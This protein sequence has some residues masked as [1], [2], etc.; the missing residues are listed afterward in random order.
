MKFLIAFAIASLLMVFIQII[1]T[2]RRKPRTM[3]EKVSEFG[4]TAAPAPAADVQQPS[5]REEQ[6]RPICGLGGMC[7]LDCRVE[8][9][10]EEPDYYEDEELDDYRG[11]ASDAYTAAE[12]E[13]FEEVLTTMR[14]EE[15]HG[16]LRSL[17]LRGVALPDALKDEA[18]MIVSEQA[19]KP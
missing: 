4:T 10:K 8:D 5:E 3:E 16:W 13:Q 6:P 11:K 7:N 17:Q 9:L 2:L 12:V 1:N 14:P 15:V 19:E 18:Y